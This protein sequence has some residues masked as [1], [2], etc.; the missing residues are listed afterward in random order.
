MEKFE[1]SLNIRS[2][3]LFVAVMESTSLTEAAVKLQVNQSKI[4]YALD[5]LRT[6]FDDPLLVRSGR[7]VIPTARASELLPQIK[8]LLVDLENLK[9][10]QDF[11]PHTADIDYTIAAN[12]FQREML[13]PELYHRLRPLVASLHLR[14]VPSNLPDFSMLR[15]GQ[16]DMVISPR[17]PDSS[18]IVQRK[19]Y[20][21]SENCYYDASQRHAPCDENDFAEADYICPSFL[22]NNR[23]INLTP[24][25]NRTVWLRDRVQ[26]I[27]Y[28]FSD[29]ISFLRGTDA[30]AIAPPQLANT[31]FKDFAHVPFPDN[32]CNKMSL[33]W[34]KKFQKDPQHAW[35]RE[36]L[37]AV[38][39]EI[40]DSY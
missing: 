24:S 15:D 11:T 6:F 10:T 1:Q 21:F 5:K 35:F 38:A 7:G 36:Q 28:G 19:L 16:I 13:L 17:V 25:Q 18:D 26:V 12:D 33:I 9:N 14:I 32:L 3:Q 2:L 34:N 4:T 22:L 23:A 37:V 29:A 30:L 27:T 40:I 20:D 31:V 39:T 8:A